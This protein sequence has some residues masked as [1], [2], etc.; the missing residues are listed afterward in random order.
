MNGFDVVAILIVL[1]SALLA[2]ARGFVREVLSIAA[3]IAGALGVLWAFPVFRE[4]VRTAIEPGWLADIA[5]VAGIFLAIYIA[6][7]LVT[8]QIH[9][10]VHSVGPIGFLD[11]S[12]GFAF[13]LVRGFAILGLAVIIL[14]AAAPADLV[15]KWLTE[16]RLY[17]VVSLSADALAAFAPKARDKAGELA[18]DAT[19]AGEA[20]AQR[21]AAE[22]SDAEDASSGVTTSSASSAKTKNDGADQKGYGDT[23]RAKLDRLINNQ[24]EKK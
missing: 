24:A 23:D 4:T 20:E 6:V 5:T 19:E 9:K 18:T 11:R 21:R 10:A 3:L 8:I 17:P 15:P 12:A 16:S 13:G 2:M 7:T 14:R 1:A 22:S